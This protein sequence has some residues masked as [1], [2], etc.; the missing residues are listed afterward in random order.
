MRE[1]I[2]KLGRFWVTLTVTVVSILL[3]VTITAVVLSV[4]DTAFSMVAGLS[5]VLAPAMIAPLMTWYVIGLLLRIDSLET[6]QRQL[7]TYDHLTQTLTRRTFLQRSHIEYQQRRK[8]MFAISCAV[9]DLDNFKVINDTYGHSGGDAVL[10]SFAA[11]LLACVGAN[12]LVGRIGGE[13]FAVLLQG[14]SLAEASTLM[15]QIRQVTE[16]DAIEHNGQLFHYTASIGISA[17]QPADTDIDQIIK[18]ADDALYRAKA[19]GKNRVEVAINP[20]G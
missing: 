7:A 15:E 17:V 13:E 14:Q 11:K 8:N 3:S 2:K 12:G 10:R 19:A 6:E 18:R 4:N 20:E 1:L 16:Q 9:I 5:S